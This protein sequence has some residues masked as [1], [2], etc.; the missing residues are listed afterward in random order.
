MRGSL[1]K[2]LRK[3]SISDDEFDKKLYKDLKRFAK[4]HSEQP[5][6]PK[7][8]RWDRSPIKFARASRDLL[9]FEFY[10][11]VRSIGNYFADL[12]DK[13]K[14]IALNLARKAGRLP[15]PELL[16]RIEGLKQY[17]KREGSEGTES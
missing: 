17:V 2:K 15:R 16:Q 1:A 4:G 8:T 7:K 9:H 13:G 10:R 5:K 14:R 6:L 12:T 11:P 3:L